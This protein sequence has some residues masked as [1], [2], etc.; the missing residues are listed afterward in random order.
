MFTLAE[1]LRGANTQRGITDAMRSASTT[2]SSILDQFEN[3]DWVVDGAVPL[4]RM[5]VLISY[6]HF[7]TML[8]PTLFKKFQRS[9]LRPDETILRHGQKFL[10]YETPNT[11]TQPIRAI[12]IP[13]PAD[14]VDRQARSRT[15]NVSR[16]RRYISRSPS[17][18][19]KDTDSSY[20]TFCRRRG[21]DLTDS[22]SVKNSKYCSYHN[23]RTHNTRD[24]R[25]R[26]QQTPYRQPG[27]AR[28]P[29]KDTTR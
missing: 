3:S 1:I 22:W 18:R 20:C 7:L 29:H 17:R 24:C 11:S 15:R 2:Q 14:V 27:E 23:S 6:I 19:R 28:P 21:H 5:A 13:T 26:R 25:S 10:K 9:Q 4:K 8:S 12:N 16:N